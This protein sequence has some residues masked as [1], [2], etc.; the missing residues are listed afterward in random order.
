MGAEF[1]VLIYKALVLSKF[2]YG[3]IIY[4]SANSS[5]LEILETVH[6]AGVRIATGAYCIQWLQFYV[7]QIFYY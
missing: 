4:G 1:Q 7:K 5:T 6:N 3:A 2:D